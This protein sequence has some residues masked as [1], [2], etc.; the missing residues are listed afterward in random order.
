MR[1]KST[2]LA[3]SV[4]ALLVLAG[5]NPSHTSSSESTPVDTPIQTTPV[6]DT[7]S[8][9]DTS[10]TVTVTITST[11]TEVLTEGTL[12]LTAEVAGVEDGKLTW[13]I[14]SKNP[15][16]MDASIAADTGVL[17]A[18]TVAGTLVVTATCEGVTAK[19][20]IT[21]KEAPVVTTVTI[22]GAPTEAVYTGREVKLDAYV[23]N[24]PSG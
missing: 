3:L 1:K 12:T 4:S 13:A 10:P 16:T 19:V 8:D 20:T 5:C 6:S 9:T 24:G 11:E 14:E 17:Q 23:T 15:E 21:V 18:G 2:L 22:L 7:G